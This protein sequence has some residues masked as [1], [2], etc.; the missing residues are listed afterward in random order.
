MLGQKPKPKLQSRQALLSLFRGLGVFSHALN[1][2]REDVK[3]IIIP[4]P[5][6]R[7]VK[8][9]VFHAHVR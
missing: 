4:E 9:Q 8:M 2:R 5:A 6:L 7:N 1:R 3:A